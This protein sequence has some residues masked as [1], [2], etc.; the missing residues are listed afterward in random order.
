MMIA[1]TLSLLE[2]SKVLNPA[3]SL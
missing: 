3:M 2:T 1:T